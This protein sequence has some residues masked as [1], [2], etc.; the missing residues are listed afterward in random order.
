[1][2]LEKTLKLQQII[3]PNKLTT[4]KKFLEIEETFN[5][6]DFLKAYFEKQENNFTL[7]WPV[8]IYAIETTGL[9]RNFIKIEEE[10]EVEDLIE[11]AFVLSVSNFNFFDSFSDLLETSISQVNTFEI[12][13]ISLITDF[14]LIK[15][16]CPMTR[17]VIHLNRVFTHGITSQL[18]EDKANL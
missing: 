12:K 16:Y 18:L 1:M 7:D 14:F 17:E 4:L 6:L 2:S 11:L 8:S 5:N 3:E 10:L 13:L 15:L 9:T